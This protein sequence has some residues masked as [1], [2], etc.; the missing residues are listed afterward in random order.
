MRRCPDRKDRLKDCL[1][2]VLRPDY[3]DD[4][5]GDALLDGAH[6][7]HDAEA[8]LMAALPDTAGADARRRSSPPTRPTPATAFA[9]ISAP[10]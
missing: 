1:I 5:L 3:D 9:S 10:R 8:R 7:A 2:E 4:G 6:R